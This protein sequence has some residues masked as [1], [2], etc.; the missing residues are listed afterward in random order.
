MMYAELQVLQDLG[1]FNAIY[2]IGIQRTM[3]NFSAVMWDLGLHTAP[4]AP[5]GPLVE[6][7]PY[8]LD[9]LTM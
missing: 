7:W 9:S 3:K 2:N 5:F 8:M 6:Y 4:S 1:I